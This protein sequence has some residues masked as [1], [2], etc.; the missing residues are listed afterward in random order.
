MRF[1]IC[2][3]TY[4][5]VSLA[6]SSRLAA[7]HGYTGLEIAPY[8]LSRD[9]TTI[10]ASTASQL[11]NHVRDAGLEVVGLH[12]LLAQTEGFHL[13]HPDSGIQQA[14]ISYAKRLADLCHG[15]GGSIMVWGSPHQRSLHGGWDYDEAFSRAADTLRTVCE[16]CSELEVTVAMEPLGACETNFLTSSAETIRLCKA[17]DHPACRLHLDVKAMSYED[18]AIP[19]VI[20][21]SMEWTVHFHANDPNLLGPGMGNVDYQPIAE[22]LKET[23]YHGWISVEVFK[24]HPSREEIALTSRE[25]LRRYF[26][27]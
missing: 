13:T 9:I 14:T 2:N 27:E 1:A 17:V 8:T 24:Y 4:G 15:L 10:K 25:N 3:E 16:H 5:D 12:W 20:R 21:D 7:A 19:D 6:E 26:D 11:G 22:A 18:A 23:Q